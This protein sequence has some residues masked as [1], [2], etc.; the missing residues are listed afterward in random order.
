MEHLDEVLRQLIAIKRVRDIFR[1]GAVAY[2]ISSV[3]TV[4]VDELPVNVGQYQQFVNGNTSSVPKNNLSDSDDEKG[5]GYM[6]YLDIMSRSGS[7]PQNEENGMATMVITDEPDA[8]ENPSDI[9]DV[10][11]LLVNVGEYQQFGN[12]NTSSIPKNDP[13]VSDGIEEKEGEA[14][15][16]PAAVPA[17]PPSA[18]DIGTDKATQS[19]DNKQFGK[20]PQQTMPCSPSQHDASVALPTHTAEGRGFKAE[21]RANGD[22]KGLM[23]ITGST[24]SQTEAKTLPPVHRLLREKLQEER[25]IVDYRFVEDYSFDT[26]SAAACV[27]SGASRSGKE[28]WKKN[29]V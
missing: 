25:V 22:G 5:S 12:G 27:V 17:V 11:E 8:A 9:V 23:V 10:D 21:G 13:S 1:N 26:L 4:D 19:E 2:G 7:S 28:T 18:S 14:T 20:E 24:I 15:S 3:D 6:H 29:A 16:K